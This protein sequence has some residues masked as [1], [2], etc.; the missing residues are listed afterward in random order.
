MIAALSLMPAVFTGCST[1]KPAAAFRDVQDSVASRT[2]QST[3]WVHVSATNEEAEGRLKLLLE[4]ELTIETAQQIALFNNRSLQ[5]TFE[6]IGISQGDLVQAG[7]L[8]NPQISARVRFPDRPPLA[9]NA[10][11][12]IADNLLDLIIMPLK[13]KIAAQQLEQTKLRVGNEILKL[14]AEVKGAYFTLQARE[15]LLARLRIVA[16]ANEVAAEL[17]TKQHDAGNINELDLINQ[18]ALYNQTKL[19]LT[20]AEV[21]GHLEREKLNRLL[22][23][24]GATNWIRKERVFSQ[25]PGWQDGYGAFTL[26]I[27]EKDGLIKYIIGQEEHHRT[28]SFIDEYKRLLADAGIEFDERYLD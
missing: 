22:G 19:E 4:K 1:V 9:T 21:Q 8:K 18:Q 17:A 28:E 3:E 23:L 6:E 10:E 15:Q 27:K 14:V 26:S 16:E 24:S 11:Y 20:Q 13:K 5:A 7:L 2:G 25:W 12:S